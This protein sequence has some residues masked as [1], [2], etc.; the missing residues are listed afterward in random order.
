VEQES[1][2]APD[3]AERVPEPGWGRERHKH[4]HPQGDGSLKKKRGNTGNRSG[5]H[6]SFSH[7]RVG[8][9]GKKQWTPHRGGRR[10]GTTSENP[11]NVSPQ[12]LI[13][14]EDQTH[15]QLG[16]SEGRSLSRWKKPMVNRERSQL[17]GRGDFS[18]KG[19]KQRGRGKGHHGC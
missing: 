17:A 13:T 8:G 15:P 3:P 14:T 4:R 10:E 18:Q 2:Q 1:R 9:A 5:T 6:P 7:H 16:K 12:G 19:R 11:G